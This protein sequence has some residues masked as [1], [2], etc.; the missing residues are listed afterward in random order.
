MGGHLWIWG[1]E[2]QT[3]SR[4]YWDKQW[5]KIGDI[6]DHLNAVHGA[7]KPWSYFHAGGKKRKLRRNVWF[8]KGST[9]WQMHFFLFITA[10]REVFFGT[11]ICSLLLCSIKN[12]SQKSGGRHSRRSHLPHT[13]CPSCNRTGKWDT[14]RGQKYICIKHC[15]K[16][17]ISTSQLLSWIPLNI[18]C[19]SR[20]QKKKKHSADTMQHFSLFEKD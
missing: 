19:S 12:L 5:I 10:I 4:A 6:G 7:L 13:I 9:S 18:F 8:A 2:T 20:G 16:N 14:R 1:P 11:Y 3:R 17:P 15:L